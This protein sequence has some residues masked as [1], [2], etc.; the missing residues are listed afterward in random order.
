MDLTDSHP[1]NTGNPKYIYFEVPQ[2]FDYKTLGFIT[3]YKK[4][5]IF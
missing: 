2:F 5:V 1:R 3:P 4:Y